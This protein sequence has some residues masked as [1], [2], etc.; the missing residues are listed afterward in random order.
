MGQPEV[1]LITPGRLVP[2]LVL[3]RELA[4]ALGTKVLSWMTRGIVESASGMVPASTRACSV[5]SV[6]MY[7]AASP[8]YTLRRVMPQAWSW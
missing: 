7:G 1:A 5:A 8:A 4:S 2:G 3:L 6:M